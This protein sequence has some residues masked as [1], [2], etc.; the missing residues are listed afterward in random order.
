MI[1]LSVNNDFVKHFNDFSSR[2]PSDVIESLVEY[3]GYSKTSYSI[4]SV[5]IN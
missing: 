1:I 3:F 2:V 5:R 4:L